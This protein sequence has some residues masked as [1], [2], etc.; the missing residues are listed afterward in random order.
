MIRITKDV[1]LDRA[2][3]VVPVATKVNQLYALRYAMISKLSGYPTALYS[4]GRLQ[5]A[6]DLSSYKNLLASLLH[7]YNLVQTT[8]EVIES[9]DGVK[10]E[11]YQLDRVE[12]TGYV[13][14]QTKTRRNFQPSDED[15]DLISHLITSFEANPAA[16]TLQ[17]G[18]ESSDRHIRFQRLYKEILLESGLDELMAYNPTEDKIEPRVNMME[19]VSRAKSKEKP[20]QQ[21]DEVQSELL[22][23]RFAAVRTVDHIYQLLMDRDIWYSFVGPRTKG[24]VTTNLER[25]KTLRTFALYLLKILT[26]YQ[27]FSIET[28]MYSYQLA[29]QWLISFPPLSDETKRRLEGT[30]R[31][32]DTLK[33][34][35]DVKALFDSFSGSAQSDLKAL[36]YPAELLSQFGLRARVEKLATEASEFTLSADLSNLDQL[37]NPRLLPLTSGTSMGELN[38]I[39]RIADLVLNQK[40]MATRVDQATAWLTPSLAKGNSKAASAALDNLNITC[41]IPFTCPHAASLQV[42]AGV[43]KGIRGG[44]LLLDSGSP[45]FSY[46][47]H[48]YLRTRMRFRMTTDALVRSGYSDFLRPQCVDYDRAAELR[49]IIGYEWQTLVPSSWKGGDRSYKADNLIGNPD[50]VRALFEKLSGINFEVAARE[51]ALPHL[52]RIWATF[53]SSFALLYVNPNEITNGDFGKQVFTAERVAFKDVT[54]LNLVTGYGKPYGTTYT[55]LEGKQGAVT[56]ETSLLR[57]GNG[58]Y[59][60]FLNVVPVVT[61]DLKNDD[62]AFYGQRPVSYFTSNAKTEVVKSWVVDEGLANFS[63][64]PT[65]SVSS[66]PIIKMTPQYSFLTTRLWLNMDLYY[67]PSVSEPAREIYSLPIVENE[68]AFEKYHYYLRYLHFGPYSAPHVSITAP[69]AE[70]PVIAEAVSR[71]EKLID[72]DV[73]DL[74][75][76]TQN[77]GAK[78]AA[79][80]KAAGQEVSA[81][82][83]RAQGEGLGADEPVSL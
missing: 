4:I 73:S 76:T 24:D 34:R 13:L 2:A 18:D 56:P 8:A 58:C 3:V 52:Q 66:I 7:L 27:Y 14:Q 50:A 47:Y 77:A 65:P 78:G 37:D 53:M 75:T 57:L 10:V 31:S 68:W 67:K 33:A 79:T 35:E 16:W 49:K 19:K 59:L 83:A 51:L 39:Y 17:G 1:Q 41:S 69:E 23:Y 20:E 44:R 60:R 21:S 26:Y 81:Q 70:A 15:I 74:A 45:S 46:A 12:I 40:I 43:D 5:K 29:Q 28:F 48:E 64:L 71:I 80:I 61:D 38:V 22:F 82:N 62:L 9:M 30:I 55:L 6:I 36:V 63:L 54:G 11:R 72:K 42:E 32:H 25:A